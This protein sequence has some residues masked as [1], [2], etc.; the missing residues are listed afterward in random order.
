[1]KERDGSARKA[2][3]FIRFP[4]AVCASGQLSEEASPASWLEFLEHLLSAQST[5]DP[6]GQEDSI[7]L[8]F[9]QT[10]DCLRWRQTVILFPTRTKKVKCGKGQGN[11]PTMLGIRSY[12]DA[13]DV[14]KG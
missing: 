14:E 4:K 8:Y 3:L 10:S 1:M 7:L 2:G 5:L 9:C 13:D 6:S 12:T 11:K